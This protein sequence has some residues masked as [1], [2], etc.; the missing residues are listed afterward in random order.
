MRNW[1]QRPGELQSELQQRSQGRPDADYAPLIR[2]YFNEI[3][4]RQSPAPQ[5]N[6]E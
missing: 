5:Q 1:G 2:M 3:S 4:R 6:P